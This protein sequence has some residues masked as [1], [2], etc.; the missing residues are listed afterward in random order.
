MK[1][2]I[3]FFVIVTAVIITMVLVVESCA[4]RIYGARPHRRDRHCGCENQL[5]ETSCQENYY[6]VENQ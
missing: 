4:P 6:L 1:H 2:S 5:Q 3:R